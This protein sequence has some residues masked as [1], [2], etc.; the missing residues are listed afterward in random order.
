MK[1][2]YI[3]R[4]LIVL[5]GLT[6]LVACTPKYIQPSGG[7]TALLR[8]RVTESGLFAMV[9]TYENEACQGPLAIGLIGGSYF[10]NASGEKDR[11]IPSML[12]SMGMPQSEVI[13]VRVPGDRNFTV[14]YTQMGPSNFPIARECKLPVTFFARAGEQYEINYS[15]E[16][17]NPGKC[18]AS[19]S[20]LF[21]SAAEQV[22][23]KPVENAFKESVSCSPFLYSGNAGSSK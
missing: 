6:L 13:E 8:L 5:I 21:S 2:N 1:T 18:F 10:V 7:S 12:G 15:Y 3:H 20:R 4:S 14:L 17:G 9:H 11:T 19:I 22:Q 23:R 16:S